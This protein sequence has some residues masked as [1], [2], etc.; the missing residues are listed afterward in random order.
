MRTLAARLF[1]CADASIV[2][3]LAVLLPGRR[4]SYFTERPECAARA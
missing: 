2:A 4:M 3:R 1:T